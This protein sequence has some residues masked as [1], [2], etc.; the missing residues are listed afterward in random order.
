VKLL[1]ER[2]LDAAGLRV[3]SVTSRLKSR[4]SLAARLARPDKVYAALADV[5]DIVGLRVITHLEDDIDRVGEIIRAD[6]TLDE[7][8]SIDKR[9]K[10]PD[11]FG[12][13]SLH[14][15][16]SLSDSRARLTEYRRFADLKCEVQMRSLLQH[17]WA[18][19]EHDLGYKAEGTVPAP[20]RRRFFRLAGLLE[21]A[22]AEFS[23]LRS[24]QTSYAEQV[25]TDISTQPGTVNLDDVSV[26]QFVLSNSLV[27][28]LDERLAR[29]VKGEFDDEVKPGLAE[30]LLRLGLRTIEDLEK[31]LEANKSLV[32]KEFLLR[33][34]TPEEPWGRMSRGIS[35][36]H[37]CQLLAV[38]INGPMGLVT[39]LGERIASED[40][41][42]REG[43]LIQQ[44]IA[45][46]QEA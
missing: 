2:L 33:A 24:E 13:L 22:D 23:R 6:F 21:I 46:T 14:H 10:D 3:H 34:G 20:L 44:A 32:F 42:L 37:L 28:D 43:E 5:T 40:L 41:L 11:R 31:A 12:Y 4:H 17:A 8:H 7:D 30:Y 45:S 29:Q 35:V 25:T 39:L 26:A 16:C 27:R 38:K 18:E 9:K 1:L 15:V 36:Y 19:I